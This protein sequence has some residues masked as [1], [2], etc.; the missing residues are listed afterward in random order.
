MIFR[1]QTEI[2]LTK[3]GVKMAAGK[4]SKND[5]G[6]V[7]V[8]KLKLVADKDVFDKLED[9]ATLCRKARCH[10][11]E[12]WLLRKR[13]LIPESE[14]QAK[15]TTNKDGSE[16]PLGEATKIYHAVG[17]RY[18]RLF[19]TQT[20]V[21]IGR[22]IA[23]NLN[24]KVDW[25]E[26]VDQS[27][28]SEEEKE[29]KPKLLRRKDMILENNMRPPF[30]TALN[31]PVPTSQTTIEFTDELKVTVKSPAKPYKKIEFKLSLRKL[32]PRIKKIMRAISEGAHKQPDS[33][34]TF[35]KDTWFLYLP[36]TFPTKVN[37]GKR[38][39]LYPLLSCDEVSRQGKDRPFRV[40]FRNTENK[41]SSWYVGDGRYYRSTMTRCIG[42]RKEIGW[43]YRNRRNGSGHGRKK[44]D[45]SVRR[46]RN[47]QRNH[48]E[49]FRRKTIVGILDQCIRHGTGTLIYHKPTLYVRDH[50]WFATEGLE[51]DWT[52]FEN[53]LKNAAYR[54]G[55]DFAVESY[56]KEHTNLKSK[57][58]KDES[59]DKKEAA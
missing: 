41:K 51:W 57:K 40:D 38:M 33:Y 32:P 52:S 47:K 44:Y 56:K 4:K 27:S 46:L 5:K 50:S 20:A 37:R 42:L 11:V 2:S 9:V 18:P 21:S 43:N 53:D 58:D 23:K 19:G 26:Q 45:D 49:E 55:I 35:K 22:E 36:V 6:H 15:T 3:C 8:L 12:D 29:G 25:R 30:T 24:S 59:D 39:N 16:R 17:S 1:N 7:T 14:K 54:R 48:R 28:L 31:I 10:A 34:L 13:G